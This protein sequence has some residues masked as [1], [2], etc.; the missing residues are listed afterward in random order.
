MRFKTS[1]NADLILLVQGCVQDK[2]LLADLE[3]IS[4]ES[5]HRFE[6]DENYESSRLDCRMVC[7]WPRLEYQETE[8]H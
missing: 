2:D 3:K 7:C 6:G 1:I 4:L 5:L 8:K